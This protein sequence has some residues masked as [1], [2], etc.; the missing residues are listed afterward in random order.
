M[1]RYR[2]SQSITPGRTA[3]RVKTPHDRA[4]EPDLQAA[5]RARTSSCPGLAATCTLALQRR[6]RRT[7]SVS[8]QL[9][10]G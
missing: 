6:L 7:F 5:S 10:S 8:K 1:T 4:Q 9:E 3:R 2:P